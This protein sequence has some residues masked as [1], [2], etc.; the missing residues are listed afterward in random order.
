MQSRAVLLHDQAGHHVLE[1]LV[2]RDQALQALL[3][4]IGVP[5]GNLVVVVRRILDRR[6][7]RLH[8]MRITRLANTN[9]NHSQIR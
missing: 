7:N 1:R 5:L 9:E 8:K 4:H 3:N 2:Q 6:L